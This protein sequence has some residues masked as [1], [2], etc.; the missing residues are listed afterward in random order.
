M[1]PRLQIP[2]TEQYTAGVAHEFLNGL[3][4][5]ADFVRSNGSGLEYIDQVEQLSNGTIQFTDPRFSY[6]DSL[7]NVGYVHYTALEI[8]GKYRR[9]HANV[10]MSYTLSKANSNLVSGSVFGSSPTNPLDLSQDAGPDATDQRHNFVFSGAYDLPWG[11]QVAGIGTY[12]SPLPWSSFTNQNPTGAFFPPRPE[13]KDSHRGDNYKGV[14]LRVT[15]VF[16][17]GERF[18]PRVFWEMYN[19][20]NSLNY[21]SYNRNID[22]LTTFGEP[23]GASD[24]RRQQLGVR[25]D[26]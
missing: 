18:Q 24:M 25:I 22:N 4:L 7:T 21:T 12:R 13:P 19:M 3:M 14:D 1:D 16:K 23:T 11:F 9:H 8:Q 6:V 26:F 2:R 17:I 5:S 10:E 15:K 20:F